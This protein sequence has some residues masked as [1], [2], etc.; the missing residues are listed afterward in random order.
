[1]PVVHSQL[2]KLGVHIAR[3]IQREVL[4]VFSRWTRGET[5]KKS[6]ELS[7][8]LNRTL[9]I[10]LE[11]ALSIPTHLHARR[12]RHEFNRD[13]LHIVEDYDFKR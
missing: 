4:S 7:R 9:S 2:I 10:P 6:Q 5:L 11:V 12:G 3:A 1:M 13:Q 8:T